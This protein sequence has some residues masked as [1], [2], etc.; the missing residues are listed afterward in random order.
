VSEQGLGAPFTALRIA[1]AYARS[2]RCRSLALFVLEQTTY[3]YPQPFVRSHALAD[4][5]VYLLF[6]DSAEGYE[7][8]GSQTVRDPDELA[9]ILRSAGPDALVVAGPWVDPDALD[10]VHCHRVAPGSYCTSVWGA[11]AT[12]HR[13]WASRYSHL[14]LC[15]T[16]VRHRVSRVAVLTTTTATAL[17]AATAE[18]RRPEL[19]ATR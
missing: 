18:M 13:T 8:A 16:D 1:S 15:D 14:V 17:T 3:P 12:H 10:G 5:G 2:G 7:P 4:S 19:E 6:D 9:P 11:L